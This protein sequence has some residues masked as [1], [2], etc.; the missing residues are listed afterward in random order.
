W[1]VGPG[2]AGPAFPGVAPLGHRHA[3]APAAVA[4]EA[5]PGPD[6]GPLR[7]GQLV[8]GHLGDRPRGQHRVT[9]A[10]QHPAE[11]AASTPSTCEPAGYSQRSP[12]WASNG[13]SPS[14]AIQVSGSGVVS[15]CAGPNEASSRS[16]AAVTIGHG[17]AAMNIAPCMPK[18]Q[19]NVSRS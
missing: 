14:R 4:E 18:P 9:A 3:V 11:R 8:A 5:E 13:S 6:P 16:A 1:D 17:S 15:G 19:V 7:R 10:E 2:G 12:G